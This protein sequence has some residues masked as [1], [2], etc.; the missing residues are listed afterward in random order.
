MWYSGGMS[1]NIFDIN[2]WKDYPGGQGIYFTFRP[3]DYER[4]N[5]LAGK[6]ISL[7]SLKRFDDYEIFTWIT[8]SGCYE[9]VVWLKTVKRDQLA[10]AL[11][12]LCAPCADKFASDNWPELQ[13]GDMRT[14]MSY[15]KQNEFYLGDFYAY[16]QDMYDL[17]V[18]EFGARNAL[19]RLRFSRPL[20][21]AEVWKL[22]SAVGNDNDLADCIAYATDIVLWFD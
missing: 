22:A 16:A 6:L 5:A 10:Q 18:V 11:A 7:L 13:E 21:P 14:C 3:E 4:Y 17:P 2:E 19:L 15:C 12:Q 1:K 20:T 8:D 9:Y